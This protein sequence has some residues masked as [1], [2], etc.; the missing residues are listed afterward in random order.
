MMVVSREWTASG[1]TCLCFV[2]AH[3]LERLGAHSLAAGPF[4]HLRK[5]GNHLDH[6]VETEP[7]AA[8][9]DHCPGWQLAFD[10]ADS[11]RRSAVPLFPALPLDLIA[12]DARQFGCKEQVLLLLRRLADAV[13]D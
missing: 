2:L 8:H 12:G 1:L 7:L 3:P 10:S 4:G 11:H 5:V 6:I 13:S 9:L